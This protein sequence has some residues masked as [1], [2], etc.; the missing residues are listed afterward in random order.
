MGQGETDL[1]RRHLHLK[2]TDY[3]HDAHAH[4]AVSAGV[5]LL[6]PLEHHYVPQDAWS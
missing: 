3:L 2:Q 5:W 6:H 1:E 4:G